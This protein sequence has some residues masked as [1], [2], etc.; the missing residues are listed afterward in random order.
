M[1]L[2]GYNERDFEKNT[3]KFKKKIN[4]IAANS[5][6]NSEGSSEITESVTLQS[7]RYDFLKIMLAVITVL[8][9]LTYNE[10]AK[11]YAFIDGEINKILNKI[12]K[13][14]SKKQ[15]NTAF[16]F[17]VL[18]Y[19]EVD[20]C[21][22]FGK[23]IYSKEKRKNKLQLAEIQAQIKNV[24]NK[25]ELVTARMDNIIDEENVIS[26]DADARKKYEL[27]FNSLQANFKELERELKHYE[28]MY[29]S[30][31]SYDST[32]ET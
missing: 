29:E 31:S 22:K 30:I 2:F 19:D 6:Y 5:S 15:W 20:S 25:M 3:E 7:A 21:R 4:K 28:A 12:E 23:N 10:Q 16:A 8:D 13:S 1:G 24:I 27:E 26:K 9:G 11:D 17:C 18:L 14:V 32:L